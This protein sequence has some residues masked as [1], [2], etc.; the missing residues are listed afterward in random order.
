MNDGDAA[1]SDLRAEYPEIDLQHVRQLVRAAKR[2]PEGG[3]SKKAHLTLLRVIRAASE[4]A[5]AK[6]VPDVQ[7]PPDTDPVSDLD[8]A[9]TPDP[10]AAPAPDPD[11]APFPDPDA[12][13]VPDPDA[14]PTA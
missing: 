4:D 14:A 2:A 1:V 6:A 10:D 8:A 5:P 7:G 13:P 11:A 9:P 12:D 3:K